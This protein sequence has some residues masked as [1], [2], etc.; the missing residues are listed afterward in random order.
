MQRPAQCRSECVGRL[1]EVK[2]P[3]RRRFALAGAAAAVAVAAVVLVVWHWRSSTPSDCDTVRALVGYNREFTEQTKTSA[4]TNNPDLSTIE[5]Y[6]QWAARVKDYAGQ[7]S[8]PDLAARAESAADLAAKTADL[9]PRYRAN[10]D[11][12]AVS[13]QYA[14]IGIE[15]G[16]AITS[17]NYACPGG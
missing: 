10:P 4:R 11:D 1:N 7:L 14:N 3:I 9:V 15:F 16:N 13:R 5:Q 12:V 2:R 8:D 6:R 17:L